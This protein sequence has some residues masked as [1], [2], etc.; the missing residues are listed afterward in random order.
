MAGKDRGSLTIGVIPTIAPYWFPAVLAG[1]GIFGG[2]ARGFFSGE[3]AE[4]DLGINDEDFLEL[5][6]R[7]GGETVAVEPLGKGG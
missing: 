2:A 5:F 6:R 7:K 4:L 1:F 3:H